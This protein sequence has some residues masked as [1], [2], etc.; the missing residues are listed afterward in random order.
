MM[1]ST[2]GQY[3]FAVN[4]WLVL[5]SA[6]A[7]I[8]WLLPNH[9]PPWSSFFH[10]TLVAWALLPLGWWVALRSKTLPVPVSAQVV[11][12]LACVPV[13]QFVLGQI[14]FGGDALLAALYL[15]ALALCII[16]G[17]RW[18]ALSR[19]A[20]ALTV[21]LWLVVVALLSW[22]LAL[23]QWLG[24]DSLGV[25]LAD[26]PPGSR[27]TGNIAQANHFATL[28][29]W[30]LIGVWLLYERRSVRGSIASC[31]AGCLL[32]GI[33]MSQSRTGWAHVGLLLVAAWMLRRR[34]LVRLHPI[35]A[36]LL[37][38]GF[39]TLVLAWTPLNQALL[40]R[41]SLSLEQL[42]QGGSRIEIW[43]VSALAIL[44]QPWLGYGWT[45]VGL[46]QQA[47]ALHA[48]GA[49][50]VFG[51]AHNILLD[52]M[53]WNGLPIALLVLS[54]L[55]MWLFNRVRRIADAES[56][57]FILLL[58]TLLLHAQFEFP[59]SYAY[60]LLPAGLV[61]G[62]LET[63]SGTPPR[64]AVRRSLW[65]GTLAACA[66]V[67]AAI[68]AE[69]HAL[70]QSLM[71]YRFES[72]RVG[73]QRGSQPP[74]TV[75]LTQLGALMHFVRIDAASVLDDEQLRQMSKVV[76]RFP[77]AGNQYRLALALAHSGHPDRALLELQV[78]CAVQRQPVCA[79]A[80]EAWAAAREGDTKLPPFVQTDRRAN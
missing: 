62:I 22:A 51:D 14:R 19:D 47:M 11:A 72:A 12:A 64:H 48:P 37:A 65:W 10:E 7:A 29:A 17:A 40:L 54:A 80:A 39:A 31:A 28:M 59:Q 20:V 57:L 33:A 8:A 27:P 58:L 67:L 52:L 73:S 15:F 75:L 21:S 36:L 1:R 69:Y 41:P 9:S 46:A 23:A 18:R 53:L 3:R 2:V 16:V 78:L 5:A 6:V 13:L 4:I 79:A 30:G 45:Q 76:E 49:Q 34:A 38:V 68:T 77:S 44:A 55:G 74:P 26:L 42:T 70:E 66:L 71:R 43:R 32:L 24:L 50:V 63:D 25:L 35:A 56:A 60:F 61:A